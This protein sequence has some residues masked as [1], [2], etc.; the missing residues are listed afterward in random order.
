MYSYT[1]KITGV[2]ACHH[3]VKG[4]IKG[5]SERCRVGVRVLDATLLLPF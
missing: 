4:F 3:V 2:A 1:L 5:Q